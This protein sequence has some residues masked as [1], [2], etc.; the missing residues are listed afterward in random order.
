MQCVGAGVVFD[1]CLIIFIS[2]IFSYMEFLTSCLLPTTRACKPPI[3][4]V[5]SAPA[6]F[7]LPCISQLACVPGRSFS[8]L[9]GCCDPME[10]GRMA[11]GCLGQM[12]KALCW[13]CS[14]V[15]PCIK[16][17]RPVG[18]EEVKQALGLWKT[19]LYYQGNS[20]PF[21]Y[22]RFQSGQEWI[23]GEIHCGTRHYLNRFQVPNLK[24]KPCNCYGVSVKIAFNMNRSTYFYQLSVLQTAEAN[25]L[26][27]L[28]PL[29]SC[30][31]KTPLPSPKTT[32]KKPSGLAGSCW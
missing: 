22:W 9:R 27:Y 5:V 3:H 25:R 30:P 23:R 28:F 7:S 13:T 19:R 12:G 4:I 20:L 18:V 15:M 2:L 11:G 1:Y 8:P 14:V 6:C 31:L 32:P 29:F 21:S 16:R 26:S 24:Q 17:S 10:G